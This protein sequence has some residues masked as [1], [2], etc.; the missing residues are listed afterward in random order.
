MGMCRWATGVRQY[1]W[2]AVRRVEIRLP[3][4]LCPPGELLRHNQVEGGYH[5]FHRRCPL[6]IVGI[7]H[8]FTRLGWRSFDL[9]AECPYPFCPREEPGPVQMDDQ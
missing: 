9:L 4:F 1:N 5:F 8:A 2:L 7:I 3:P 6:A